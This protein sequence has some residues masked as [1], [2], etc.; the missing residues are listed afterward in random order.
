MS[1]LKALLD[2]GVEGIEPAPDWLERAL[3]RVRRR[4]RNRRLGTATLAL[5]LF[6]GAAT[7][8]WAVL[9]ADR[10]VTTRTALPGEPVGG[11]AATAIGDGS[12]WALTCSAKCTGEARGAQGHVVRI[13]LSTGRMV[14]S[15]PIANPQALA[16]GEGAV[17]AIDFWDGLVL[18]IDPAT[19]RVEARIALTLPFSVAG[20]DR[21]FLPFDVAAGEGSVWV[22]TARGAVARIDPRTNRVASTIRLQPELPAG[23]AVGLGETCGWRRISRELPESILCPAKRRGPFLSVRAEGASPSGR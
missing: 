17:W 5:A 10:M 9:W 23:L 6:A 13:D 15:I 4:Q 18:R 14:A 16:F 1:E 8:A 7:G 22:D 11:T 20:G 19:D 12:L 2:L 21:A 3:R